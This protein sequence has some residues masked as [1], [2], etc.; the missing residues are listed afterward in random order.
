MTTEIF[1]R[2]EWQE[3]LRATVRLAIAIV[4]GSAIGWERERRHRPAGLRTH[5]LVT[6]GSASFMMLG[7]EVAER[8][9]G[10]DPTRVLQGVAMGIGFVGA[11]AILKLPAERRIEGLTTAATIWTTA[12]I[13]V[14]IGAGWLLL[15]GTLTILTVGVLALVGRIERNASSEQP[16]RAHGGS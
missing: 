7:M 9:G 10:A 6:V 14:A 12:A 13:G 4:F 3:L 16:P 5:I 11:G 15:A 8:V 1:T 2:L